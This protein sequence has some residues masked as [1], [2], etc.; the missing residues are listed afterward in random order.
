VRTRNARGPHSIRHKFSVTET[1]RVI[2][3]QPAGLG[4]GRFVSAGLTGAAACP[5]LALAA[6]ALAAPALAALALAALAAFAALA[7]RAALTAFACVTNVL[8]RIGSYKEVLG[9]LATVWH[10][11]ST[12]PVNIRAAGGVSRCIDRF[13][14]AGCSLAGCDSCTFACFP[15]SC[16][17]PCES[18]GLFRSQSLRNA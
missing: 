9:E 5:A 16:A 11:A 6:L 14:D 1:M 13:S 2:W 7:A 17:A 3:P 18:K 15:I 4:A 10:P 12:T 8:W